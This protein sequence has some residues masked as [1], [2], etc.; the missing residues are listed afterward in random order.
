MGL[1][2]EVALNSSCVSCSWMLGGIGNQERR[3]L[4]V[5]GEEGQIRDKW[6]VVWIRSRHG[7][8]D[9]ASG[10]ELSWARMP[11]YLVGTDLFVCLFFGCTT[12]LAG[13]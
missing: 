2:R 7:G 13:S 10:V 3:Q 12:R 9:R 6:K 8:G 4:G 1:G 11:C 5:M